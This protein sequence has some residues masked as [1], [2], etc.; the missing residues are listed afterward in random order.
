MA[1]V[2]NFASE[3]VEGAHD[4]L[5]HPTHR[6]SGVYEN[7]Y[8][9]L[10]E[11]PVLLADPAS[12]YFHHIKAARSGDS[13]AMLEVTRAI[14]NCL[15]GFRLSSSESRES[16]ERLYEDGSITED[17]KNYFLQQGVA[18]EAMRADVI[19]DFAGDVPAEVGW[20]ARRR[21]LDLAVEK[22]SQEAELLRLDDFSLQDRKIAVLLDQLSASG[23]ESI[24]LKAAIFEPGRAA[25]EDEIYLEER[26]IYRACL[27]NEVCDKQKYRNNL[28]TTHAPS[29]V[30]RI[31]EFADGFP[32]SLSTGY[33]QE[34]HQNQPHRFE[35]YVVDAYLRHV[36]ENGLEE[37][38]ASDGMQGFRFPKLEPDSE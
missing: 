35:P 31:L 26:W 25:D 21:W 2:K 15:D 20:T 33:F 34:L 23:D 30:T 27:R 13:R 36:K 16:V 5:E 28:E 19:L 17:L 3:E 7:P 10:K 14:E 24:F 29:D 1:S 32:R 6:I 8:P 4:E 9:I 22:G 37:A 12:H 18:C 38:V 11:N